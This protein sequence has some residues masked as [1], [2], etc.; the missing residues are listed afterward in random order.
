ML[1]VLILAA[2]SPS[3]L[4]PELLAVTPDRGWTGED[5]RVSIA[6]EHLLPALDLGATDPVDTEFE[7]WI[8]AEPRQRLRGI[9]LSD[10]Q[11]LSATVPAGIEPGV[12]DLFVTTPTGAEAML[13]EAF[14]VTS[15]RADHLVV[16]TGSAAY[17]LGE[18][19][20]LSLALRD[21]EDNVVAEAMP[22]EIVATSP[23]GASGVSFHGGT[24]QGV[25]ALEEGV[26]LEGMLNPDGTAEVLAF[27]TEPDDVTFTVRALGDDGIDDGSTLLSWD[28]GGLADVEIE[29]PFSPFRTAA[30]E[31]FT[32]G[33]VLRDQYG[34]ELPDTYARILLT[35]DCNDDLR[36]VVD[37]VGSAEVELTLTR[38]CDVDHLYALNTSLS[39]ESEAFEV[40][41]AEHAAFDVLATPS[42]VTAG[43]EP[44]LVLVTAVD[45]FKNTLFDYAGTFSLADSAGGLDQARTSCPEFNNGEALCVTYL[46]TAGTAVVVSATD[47]DDGVEGFSDPVVVQPDAPA[48]L[49]VRPLDTTVVAGAPFAV[50]VEVTDAWSNVIE[51][52]PGGAD[53]IEF[54]DDTGTVECD[55][56]GPLGD[57]A[58]AFSCTITVATSDDSLLAAAPRMSLLGAAPDPIDVDNGALAEVTLTA[59]AGA[60]AGQ[61]FTLALA[62]YDAYGNAY[63]VQSDPVVDLADTTGT[64]DLAIAN[65]DAAGEAVVSATVTRSG[66]TTLTA[67]QGGVAL[68][69]SAVIEV[70]A[71]SMSAFE[72]DPGG[73]I[74]VSEGGMVVVAAIDA[75]G[76]TVTSYTGTVTLSDDA[77]ACD[78]STLSSWSSGE[79]IATFDCTDVA[80]A[81]VFR[82]VDGAG[83]TGASSPVDVVDLECTGGPVADLVIDGDA[84]RVACLS[85][86]EVTVDLDG[87][88]SS[89]SGL[90]YVFA[91]S[92]G[93][94]DR[95]IDPVVARTW[96]G[97]GPRDVHLLVV[98]A[99]GCGSVAEAR[100]WVGEDDGEPTGP[101]SVS[102]AD[103]SV[104]TSGST[105]VSA[106]ATD[107]NGDVASGQML[108]VRVDLGATTA[109]S[110]G[111]G[112]AVTLDGSGERSFTWSFP[113]GHTGEATVRVGS[114]SGGGHGDGSVTV[115]QDSA[116]PHVVSVS[117]TG[118]A[119]EEVTAITVSFDED[120]LESATS[121]VVLTGPSGTESTTQSLTG[122]TLTITP[123]SPLDGS[124][125]TFSVALGTGFRDEAGNRLAGDWTGSASAFT[126]SFG[127]VADALPLVAGCAY[128]V[129]LIRPDGDDGV[130]EESDSVTITPVTS[131]APLWWW[132]QVDDDDG[133]RI[134]SDRAPGTDP[135]M[136]WDGRAD[137]GIIVASGEYTVTLSPID[138]YGNI[139]T[140]CSS[141]VTVD[142]R[143]E[144]P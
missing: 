133:Q 100:A 125:G 75:F 107:C 47:D 9:E 90:L 67:S 94:R 121:D 88:A 86:D 68:G 38:A 119:T 52:E 5:T 12:Y 101:V 69:E 31:P 63:L 66:S 105:T 4:V 106:S 6:G 53:P 40:I 17:D 48:V 30:G 87:S 49:T 36:E 117:P 114:F 78:G 76:N 56:T 59:P 130:G 41:P 141:T 98:E 54:S 115:T 132:L 25:T 124:L 73:W 55:W 93:V 123:A 79:A 113:A 138:A 7:A 61:S 140:A 82:G 108:Y 71:G 29:L 13:T 1:A 84:E 27:S 129:A 14:R 139:G 21:P 144:S 135:D 128:D 77:G 118:L 103:A 96:S 122:T 110:T 24:L 45:A 2:C 85:S 46:D 11:S 15:T 91:D 136:S 34:N 137:S 92:E 83:R 28:A 134:R 72:V 102:V 70:S 111:A 131:G 64:L 43:S 57:G 10:Y 120:M 32:V 44:L 89:G 18:S 35:D 8:E 80:L 20:T 97:A 95:G 127:N 99:D 51:I 58:H 33:L 109:T 16:T 112:L 74:V 19:A 50:H 37:V 116:R 26:G 104:A 126:T 22:I 42:E 143:L 142:H 3:G 81:D 23:S 65:L 62:G 60:T 39:V